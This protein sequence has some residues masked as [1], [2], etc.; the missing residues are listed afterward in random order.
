MIKTT[1]IE[2]F[3][4]IILG[5][6]TSYSIITFLENKKILIINIIVWGLIFLCSILLNFNYY[7][8]FISLA[9]IGVLSLI[10]FILKLTNFSK[11]NAL[12]FWILFCVTAIS[13]FAILVTKK[14][15]YTS[16]SDQGELGDRG[17]I[18][19]PGFKFDKKM[20][21]RNEII[22]ERCYKNTINFVDNLLIEIADAN[23]RKIDRHGYIFKNMY[24]K[25]WI[26]K[27]CYSKQFLDKIYNNSDSSSKNTRRLVYNTCR[28]KGNKGNDN[29]RVCVNSENNEP[30]TS[31]ETKQCLTDVDCYNDV[32]TEMR[33]TEDIELNYTK[34]QKL[35][36]NQIKI[37][38]LEIL[39]NSIE[40]NEKT[41]KKLGITYGTLGT[42]LNDLI[43]GTISGP[44]TSFDDYMNDTNYLIYYKQKLELPDIG[45]NYKRYNNE[46]GWKFLEN[47]FLNEHFWSSNL[48]K[49][50]M[51]KIKDDKPNKINPIC[52]IKTYFDT[53]SKQPV[54]T[55]KCNS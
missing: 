32:K 28:N 40:D 21:Y 22:P 37:W 50:Y 44:N 29:R 13:I 31:T 30:S 46:L 3:I 43:T 17:V 14:F 53:Y 20:D 5:Y 34:Y 55:N 1:A 18:G 24:L 2:S 35:L 27:I 9:L 10:I 11:N 19:N 12:I 6:L 45:S 42:K 25:S 16:L 52:F 26:R 41:K 15:V 7:V 4:I 39:R 47:Y 23:G 48:N 36:N 51:D 49:Q 54:V 33:I 8:Y 38:I